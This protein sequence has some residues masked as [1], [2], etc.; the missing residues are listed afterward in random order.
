MPGP[1][2]APDGCNGPMQQ[3]LLTCIGAI[4]S[5]QA[6][7]CTCKEWRL[8]GRRPGRRVGGAG[9]PDR[10]PRG[11]APGWAAVPEHR[12]RGGAHLV[13][14]RPRAEAHGRALPGRGSGVIPVGWRA[15]GPHP[16]GVPC[17]V[18]SIHPK[19]QLQARPGACLQA[20]MYTVRFADFH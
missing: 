2:A 19:V 12:E 7:P 18:R 5:C 11:H 13:Q 6:P 10:W 9:L 20:V 17:P 8:A 1:S 4:S 3:S 14:R 15:S 16:L